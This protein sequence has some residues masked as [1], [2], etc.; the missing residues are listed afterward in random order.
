MNNGKQY[1]YFDDK[2]CEYIV[3]DSRTPRPWHNFLFN[4][5]YLVNLTQRG[6]GSSFYQPR[7]EGLRANVTEDRDGNG[8]ARFVYIR[9][10][11][12]GEYASITGAPGIEQ[13]ENWQC[14][15]GRGYQIN[16]STVLGLNV[17]WRVFVPDTS[18]P[19]ELWTIT[20]SNPTQETRTVSV[21]PYLEMHLT[22]G[23]TLM[24]F[25]AVLGGF[26]DKESR[27]VFG[28]NSCV[29]FPCYFKA[30]LASDT[31]VS[32]VT[33]SRDEFLGPYRDYH[34]PLAVET[35]NVHNPE[36]GTEWLGASLQHPIQLAPGSTAV[37]NCAVGV[38][39]SPAEGRALIKAYLAAGTPE[40]LFKEINTINQQVDKTV[41]VCTPDKQFNRWVNIWMK[42]QLRFVC[43]WGRVIGRGFRD[44][45]QD[46]LGHRFT[47]Q[48]RA[49]SCIK[50][51]FAKQ[52]PSGKCIRAWRL[53]NAQLDLQDYADSPSWM[54][55]ALSFYLKETGDMALLEESVPFLNAADPYAEPDSSAS[56]WE[57]AIIAQRHLLAER[58]RHGLSLIHYGDWCDTLNG[59]G[60]KGAGESVMLSMQVKWGCELL[61]EIAEQRGEAALADE[62]RNGAAELENAIEQHAWDGAWYRRAFDDEGIAVGTASPPPGDMNEGLIFLN[63]QSW[64]MISGIGRGERQ[65]A[66]AAAAS[67]RL[68]KGYGM[69]LNDPAYSGL[70]PRIGQ[71]T[72]MT[73]G[74]Y[75]NGSVYVHGNCFWIYGLASAGFAAEAYRA[76]KAVLPDT[77][78]KPLTDTE[79]FTVPNFYI[80]PAVARRQ[81]KNLYLS[82][83]R[84]GSTAWMFM[85]AIECIMGIKAEFA[86]LRIAPL[87]PPEWDS[88]VIVRC[89]RGAE[90]DIRIT[91][92]SPAANNVSAIKVNGKAITGTLLSPG[93]KGQRYLVEVTLDT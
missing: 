25:I 43:R 27:A 36:A 80:G 75:E 4:D 22:G 45:L 68:D 42:H 56:V 67:E 32:G 85:T 93:E 86:G 71:M 34:R 48:Q 35:G 1:G 20:V 81:Q 79:P 26:Y 17:A 29:K 84:T 31:A 61:R 6:T 62:M 83:W 47:E 66:A 33:V 58:G 16:S 10:N 53:P 76:W 38:C 41:R 89:F 24:D 51:V 63:P 28:I 30:F 19:V 87:L 15:I 14:R 69:V 65:A 18:D 52:Y 21:F 5:I 54:I 74:F 78:N 50:E 60:A 11:S 59:V 57:H 49:R 91:R 70:K 73:P 40:K 12:N 82:G 8:G 90:Y 44:I 3:T 39:E 37:I 13:P 72:A 9:D 2:N 92:M 23:S 7:G 77:P 88:A 46:T 55:M 64:A